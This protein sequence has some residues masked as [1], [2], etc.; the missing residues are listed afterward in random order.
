MTKT[1]MIVPQWTDILPL[2]MPYEKGYFTGDPLPMVPEE[3]AKSMIR[4]NRRFIE[5]YDEVGG[6]KEPTLSAVHW[7]EA[8]ELR[9]QLEDMIGDEYRI[10]L[11]RSYR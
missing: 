7:A 1:L 9:R 8:E 5:N 2:E 11:T 6:W 10:I 3:I 4:W